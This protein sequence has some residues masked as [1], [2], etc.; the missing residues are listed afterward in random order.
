M[1]FIKG[2]LLFSIILILNIVNVKAEGTGTVVIYYNDIN[3]HPI[4]NKVERTTC[5]VGTTYTKSAP[6]INGYTYIP[7]VSES[8]TYCD[9]EG[10]NII[11]F[12]YQTNGNKTEGSVKVSCY[13]TKG[14]KIYKCTDGRSGT[15]GTSYEIKPPTLD[16][17]T[18][19]RVEGAN[20]GTFKEGSIEVKFIYSKNNEVKK[21][22]TKKKTETKIVTKKQETKAANTADVHEDNTILE[23]INNRLSNFKLRLRFDNQDKY[24]IKYMML[25]IFSSLSIGLFIIRKTLFK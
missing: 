11:A 10:E 17:Y 12:V 16:G 8:S 6:K 20:K 5:K 4:G 21:V 24:T 15:I 2:V 22:V 25:G 13:D 18:L 1:K 3:N 23:D 7:S 14:N 9:S 19:E